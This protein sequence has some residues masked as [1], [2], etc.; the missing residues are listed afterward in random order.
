[1]Y[2]QL[3]AQYLES[4]PVDMAPGM[5]AMRLLAGP[6]AAKDALFTFYSRERLLSTAARAAWVEPDRGPVHVEAVL[7]E[8]K[9]TL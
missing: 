1:V 5:R 8:E 7:D 4:G 9:T 3:I 6:L 2:V